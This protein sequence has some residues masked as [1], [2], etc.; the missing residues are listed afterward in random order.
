MAVLS[1][2]ADP[3]GYYACEWDLTEDPPARAYWL[4]LFRTH[5]HSIVKLLRNDSEP[6]RGA[7]VDA[8]LEDY[9]RGLEVL[10]RRPDAWGRLTVLKLT[11]YRQELQRRHGFDDPFEAIKAQETRKAIELYPHVVRR[12]DRLPEEQRME[13]LARGIFAGNEFDL[14]CEATTARYHDD[15]HDFE[16][17][18]GRIAPR[19]WPEDDL[20][21]WCERLRRGPSYRRVL[22]FVDNAGADAVLGCL[23]LARWLVQ[24]GATVTLAANS[25]PALNDITAA[26]LDTAIAHLRPVDAVLDAAVTD[27]RLGT[28]ASGCGTPLI[29]LADVSDACNEAASGSD[30]II[31]EGMG[32]SVESNRSA[33][34]TCDA[35]WIA[36]VKDE[37][38]ADRVGVPLFSPLWR[39]REAGA[40]SGRP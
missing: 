22:F 17:A 40:T 26:E 7:R 18:M 16:E 15:G 39:F 2:L 24:R 29:D 37:F 6:G 32:R 5:I 31:L 30:L 14:G 12:L 8:F 13:A 1:L 11:E 27:G 3:Q 33:V 38:V 34:F 20:D 35:L 28:V 21:A 36:L 25:L 23:P 9:L 10:D 19:P 4:N